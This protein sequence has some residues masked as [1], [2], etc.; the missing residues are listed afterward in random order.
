M[1]EQITEIRHRISE[2]RRVSEPPEFLLRKPVLWICKHLFRNRIRGSV[3]LNYG[4]ASSR[5]L[6]V[7]SDQ[8]GSAWEWYPWIGLKKDINRNRFWFLI[9][10]LNIWKDFKVLS[11]F[12]QKW[13]QPLACSDHDLDWILSSYWLAHFYLLKKSAKRLH[14]FG[15][16]C[17]MLE[18]FTHEP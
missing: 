11:C 14:Y 1:L 5:P 16:D 17:G 15:L 2:S 12:I 13:I 3:I 9:S 18:Y 8:I 10:I 7:P 6:K 4:Y